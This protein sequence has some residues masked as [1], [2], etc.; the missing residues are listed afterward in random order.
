MN[1]LCVLSIKQKLWGGFA[2][3][4]A[5]LV[6][7]GLNTLWSA[8]STKNKVLRMTQ[9]IQPALITSM[10]LR[11]VL[12]DATTSLGFF[13]LTNEALHKQNFQEVVSKI[14]NIV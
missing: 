6:I 12:K 8:S 7:S 10:E 2:L 9:E 13:S 5:I 14:D 1:F 4:L 3:I 11:S